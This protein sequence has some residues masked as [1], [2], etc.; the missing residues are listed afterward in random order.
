MQNQIITVWIINTCIAETKKINNRIQKSFVAGNTN[1]IQV[2]QN[3]HFLN[4]Q[5]LTYCTVI[6]NPTP[7]FSFFYKYHT[8]K[9]TLLPESLLFDANFRCELF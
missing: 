3:P 6:L 1:G 4:Y 7:H 5:I 8:P 2:S 9:T